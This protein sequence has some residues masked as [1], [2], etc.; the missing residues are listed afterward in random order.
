MPRK[1]CHT[2]LPPPYLQRIWFYGA[3]SPDLEAYPF[4]LPLFLHWDFELEFDTPFTIIVGENGSG[5]ST[6]LEG[7]ER[8]FVAQQSPIRLPLARIVR[9]MLPSEPVAPLSVVLLT[10]SNV[11]A[12]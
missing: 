8:I 3:D 5:K 9:L 12:V 2:T 6:L 7:I 11:V 1:Y 4:C 10:M